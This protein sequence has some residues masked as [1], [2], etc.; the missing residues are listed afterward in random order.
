MTQVNVNYEDPEQP[1]LKFNNGNAGIDI[2]CFDEF[3]LPNDG[4]SVKVKTGIKIQMPN[5][6]WCKIEGRSGLG[7]RGVSIRGGV[8]DPSYRG[9]ICV[10]MANNGENEISFNRHDRVAQLVFHKIL[11]ISLVSCTENDFDKTERGV[12]GFGSSGF[13]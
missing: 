1:H 9:E 10:I 7:L 6:T 12:D 2:R 3:T 8:I 13:S 5:D 4:K 11:D